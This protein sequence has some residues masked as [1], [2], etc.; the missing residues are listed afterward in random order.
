[1]LLKTGFDFPWDEDLM[2][3]RRVVFGSG[4]L[5][6]NTKVQVGCPDGWVCF[7]LG[8]WSFMFA[9]HEDGRFPAVAVWRRAF[10]TT[11]E[12]TAAPGNHDDFFRMV[13]ERERSIKPRTQVRSAEKDDFS[14]LLDTL[15]T[16]IA[17]R[18]RP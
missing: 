4:E 17:P 6:G 11:L 16:D 18:W 15:A 2:I 9:I 14:E 3:P 13:G 7:R 8:C 12:Q 5:S 1:M 10:V